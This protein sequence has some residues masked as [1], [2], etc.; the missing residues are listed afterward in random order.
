LGRGKRQPAGPV[1]KQGSDVIDHCV[2]TQKSPL[3]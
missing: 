3:Q 1:K 2:R